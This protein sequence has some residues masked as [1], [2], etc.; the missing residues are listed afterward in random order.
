[1]SAVSV[2]LPSQAVQ[3][4]SEQSGRGNDAGEQQ[5]QK[6]QREQ[7]AAHAQRAGAQLHAIFSQ[8][9]AEVY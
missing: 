7:E 9:A 6:Q 2:G 4:T 5:V 8:Q 1:M 3:R